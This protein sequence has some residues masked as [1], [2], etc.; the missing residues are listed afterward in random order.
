MPSNRPVIVIHSPA[1]IVRT[2]RRRK[3]T[4]AAAA[5]GLVAA[6]AAPSPIGAILDHIPY[7]SNNSAVSACPADAGKC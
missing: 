2:T 6:L 5:L 4:R 1:E 7:T 3:V